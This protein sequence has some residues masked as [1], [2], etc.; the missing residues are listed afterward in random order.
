MPGRHCPVVRGELFH[1]LMGE[2]GRG[3]EMGRYG[4]GMYAETETA[5]VKL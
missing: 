5:W 2:L 3:L 1:S 4:I